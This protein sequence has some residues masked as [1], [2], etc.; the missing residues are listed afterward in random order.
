MEAQRH[1]STSRLIKPLAV[2]LLLLMLVLYVGA[3]GVLR[4]QGLRESE[5]YGMTGFYYVS[6]HDLEAD[7]DPDQLMSVH[8][9]R[10]VFFAPINWLDANFFGGPAPLDGGIRKLSA[11]CRGADAPPT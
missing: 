6:L 3:Y 7:T 9:L 11:E 1:P 10:R 2:G 8:R 4:S 5:E